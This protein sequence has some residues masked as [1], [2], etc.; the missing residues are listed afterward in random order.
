MAGTRSLSEDDII[1]I[2]N[3]EGLPGYQLLAIAD[4]E[5]SNDDST[6]SAG[7]KGRFQLM[8]ATF[9]EVHP[10]GDINDPRDNA[11]AAA[12]YLRKG[13]DANGGDFGGAAAQY[14]AGPNWKNKVA[15]APGVKYGTN[16]D[17]TGGISIEDYQAKA[18]GNAQKYSGT[19]G[20]DT[21]LAYSSTDPNFT[22]DDLNS[23]IAKVSLD[24]NT[25]LENMGRAS[26]T[27]STRI[28][29]NVKKQMANLDQQ[30][31]LEAKIILDKH[32]IEAQKA[33][34]ATA[35]LSRLGINDSDLDSTIAQLSV[36]MNETYK[37]A[38]VMRA[39]I[40]DRQNVGLFDDPLA[41]IS[42]QF[43]L[44]SEIRQH[45]ALIED[46]AS[47]KLY[48][49][50]ATQVAQSV[51][52][53]NAAKFTVTSLEGAQAAAQLARTKAHEQAIKL[54]DQMLKTDFETQART[55]TI[56][57]ARQSALQLEEQ[58]QENLKI[59]RTKEEAVAAEAERVKNDN[60]M[61]AVAARILGL[62][63]PDRK[64]LEKKPKDEKQAVEYLM[65]NDGGIGKDP[66]EAY[67]VLK[68]GN[69]GKMAVITKQQ[70]DL[71]T[72]AY[73]QASQAAAIDP[74]IKLAK[75]AQQQE[76]IS[77][78]MREIV[79]LASNDPN[80]TGLK[81]NPY[82]MPSLDT[83]EQLPETGTSR[84]VALLKDFKK[85][86]PNRE[87]TDS[88]IYEIARA[89]IGPTKAYTDFTG[90]AK[91]IAKYYQAGVKLNNDKVRFNAF[92]MPDQ[93]DYNVTTNNGKVD[94]TSYSKLMVS[95]L[96]GENKQKLLDFAKA[97]QAAIAN[98]VTRG[99]S[100][101]VTQKELEEFKDAE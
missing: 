89:N 62:D 50:Q 71:L 41:W 92:G 2:A 48:A 70:M 86:F 66:L 55:F 3:S 56:L 21:L 12:R 100:G 19:P 63:I 52:T 27:L 94:L 76:F 60:Q 7:A 68:R 45:N 18:V 97:P 24:M 8:P 81:I 90:A 44:P 4:K 25:A 54:E 10:E 53:E 57:Q 38:Q 17:G 51:R 49:D 84:L 65:A 36:E 42:N 91:D 34:A 29:D 30:G 39:D 13:L 6:S 78:K 28:Q 35:E 79:N 9:K 43:T 101:E 67:Q 77:K 88:Q 1:D 20:D 33:A 82:K 37:Q 11:I 32:S 15:K 40:R 16:A 23:S 47:K 58:R 74:E 95:F 5:D 80:Y 99:L 73:N 46:I 61:V 64:T 59:K 87:L 72:T 14:Y 98:K 69:P 85:Q 96:K 31:E 93:E 26:S 22:A 83:M 75:P